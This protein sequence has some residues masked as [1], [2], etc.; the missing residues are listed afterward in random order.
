MIIHK[1]II[2]SSTK[3]VLEHNEGGVIYNDA[4]LRSKYVPLKLSILRALSFVLK[5]HSS[6]A[7]GPGKSNEY[8]LCLTSLLR[9]SSRE[10]LAPMLI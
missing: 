10:C 9:D 4:E 7:H 3:S 5:R 8:G 6:V 2:S 1:V